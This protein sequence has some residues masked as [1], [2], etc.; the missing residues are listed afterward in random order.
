MKSNDGMRVCVQGFLIAVTVFTME[1]H[2][3]SVIIS[4]HSWLRGMGQC[5]NCGNLA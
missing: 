1:T 3:I 2:I 4:P 5:T